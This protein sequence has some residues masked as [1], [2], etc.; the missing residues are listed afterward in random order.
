MPYHDIYTCEKCSLF[1][2]HERD[3]VSD[4]AK[5][6]PCQTVPVSHFGD[7]EHAKIWL[8]LTNP[9]GHRLD[10][11]VG[12]LVSTYGKQQTRAAL[13]GQDIQ[14]IFKHFSSYF[15]LGNPNRN[16][17]NFFCNWMALLDGII[18]SKQKCTFDNGRIC[19]VDLIKCPTITDWQ[20]YARTDE[21]KCVRSNC[22]GQVHKPGPSHYIIRQILHHNPPI[23]IFA[24]GLAGYIGI[25]Y[26]GRKDSNLCGIAQQA[27]PYIN[28]AFSLSS[29]KRVSISLAGSRIMNSCFQSASK[30]NNVKSCIQNILRNVFP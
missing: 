11:N 20:R 6:G 19:A 28:N 7:I 14:N 30:I 21:S 29:P 17:H 8:I 22:L 13:S 24:Q 1:N 18:V 2:P 25:T 12:H 23:L 15:S 16:V 4:F 26:R 27:Q 9:K 5:R 10:P 3:G